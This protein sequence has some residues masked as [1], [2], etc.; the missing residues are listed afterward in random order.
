MTNVPAKIVLKER[1][2][3]TLRLLSF[4]TATAPLI[5]KASETFSLPEGDEAY[6]DERRV[7]ERLQTLKNAKLIRTDQVPGPAG[8]LVNYYRLTHEGYRTVEEPGAKFPAKS[9]F[10]PLAMSRVKHTMRLA[11][12]IVHTL[13]AAHRRHIRVTQFIRENEL[14]M[15]ETGTSYSPDAHLQLKSSGRI[16][17]LMLE[18][19]QSTE[20]LESEAR[21]AIK[22][23]LLAYE[24]HQDAVLRWWFESGRPRRI[25]PR[26]RTV[27]LTKTAERAE[28]IAALA[29]E[30]ARNNDRLVCYCATQDSFLSEPDALTNGIFIDHYG[31]WQSLVS[32]HPSSS[33]KRTPIRLAV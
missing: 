3:Q 9:F 15:K 24:A 8:A 17:N 21:N 7:R 32:L 20:P 18:I 16:F 31:R 27:F 23:K 1:D 22:K 12:V 33:A 19:D 13:T 6:R 5:F 11:E 14:S 26:F 10:E 2:R 30:I 28:H 25:N 29:S 4:T